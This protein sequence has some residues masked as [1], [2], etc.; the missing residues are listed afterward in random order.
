MTTDIPSQNRV[1]PPDPPTGA[2]RGGSRRPGDQCSEQTSAWPFPFAEAARDELGTRAWLLLIAAFALIHFLSLAVALEIGN[3]DPEPNHDHVRVMRQILENGYP[4]LPTWPPGFGY[5]LALKWH[6]T[7]ALGLPYWAGKLLLDPILFVL[8]GVFSTLLG[9]RLTGNRWLAIFSGFGLTAAPLFVLAS[10]EGLAVLLFQPLFLAALL[11]LVRQL[12]RAESPGLAG[13]VGAGA[14]LGLATLVR[15][16]PQFLLVALA[17]LFVLVARRG[18][19][20]P[21]PKRW[22]LRT[23]AA[24]FAAILAQ[25][26]V[27]TPWS[28][29]QRRSGASGVFT[30]N[31]LYGS[32]YN[33][34]KRQDGTRVADDLALSDRS[35]DKS[36]LGILRFHAR[37][38]REDPIA[39]ASIYGRKL[40]RAW[41]LSSSGRWDRAIALCHAP[42]WLAAL[43][44]FGLWL[45]RAPRDPAL[46]LSLLVIGYM[47]MVSALVSGLARY[48]APIYGFLGIAAGIAAMAVVAR[49]RHSSLVPR[50]S[51]GWYSSAEHRDHRNRRA[52]KLKSSSSRSSS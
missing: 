6:V 40:V 1:P 20:G 33:G 41:Y 38:L 13:F 24:L 22:L 30:A 35:R 28:L 10:A 21:R 23:A 12:Q 36:V 32:F 45:R 34:M 5:Y 9:L 52:T 25:A 48:L 27:L 46:W 16:N 26:I 4:T 31:V 8:S 18:A 51:G 11:V 47:W 15:A 43:A 17:P 44:G 42:L 19:S 39:L 3:F 2:S 7:G 29:V 14:L 37:W 50:R 49:A